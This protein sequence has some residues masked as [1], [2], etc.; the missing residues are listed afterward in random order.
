MNALNSLRKRPHISVSQIKCFIQC[1]KK[2]SY[3]YIE[4]AEPDFKPIALAFGTAW[5]SAVEQHL[6]NPGTTE[7]TQELFRDVLARE[8]EA[9]LA[10]V[11]FEDEETLGSCIDLGTRMLDTFIAQVDRPDHVIGTEVAF[12]LELLDPAT[13]EPLPIPLIGA[14]DAVVVNN[15]HAEIWE[16]KTA[17]RKWTKDQ[18]EYDLQPTVYKMGV[19][20][21]SIDDADIKLIVTTKSKKPEV[22]IE[23]AHRNGGD[24]LDLALTA[25]SLLRAMEAGVDHPVRGW[26][27]RSCQYASSCR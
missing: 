26:Q 24:E 27:C 1:A 20:V 3:A 22:Q 2:H 15:D 17:K 21:H 10:P 11:L 23:T 4:R 5:H 18:L 16:L 12:A 25:A 7:E 13:A 6:L 14:I 8:V 9:G 19:R